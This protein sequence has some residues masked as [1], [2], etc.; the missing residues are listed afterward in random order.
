V[1]IRY[2]PLSEITLGTLVYRWHAFPIERPPLQNLKGW[3][4]RL[5]ER[6]AFK[7]HIEIPIT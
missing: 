1:S 7:K 2:D 3:F 5:R 6:P 4:D